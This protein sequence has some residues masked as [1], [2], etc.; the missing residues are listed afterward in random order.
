MFTWPAKSRVLP[1]RAC[2]YGLVH[3]HW[4]LR[5]TGH[6]PD[7][8][9]SVSWTLRLE[10]CCLEHTFVWGRERISKPSHAACHARTLLTLCFIRVLLSRPGCKP[11]DTKLAGTRQ[12]VG[13]RHVTGRLPRTRWAQGLV[14]GGPVRIG[15]HR[16][17]R[18]R[19]Y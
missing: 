11:T 18:P 14:E 13:V 12:C 1:G 10:Y 7:G 6:V 5:P 19:V 16:C 15:G 2:E 17:P 8:G 4:S 3:S 9:V